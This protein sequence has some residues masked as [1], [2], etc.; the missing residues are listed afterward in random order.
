[1]SRKDRE[2]LRGLGREV[3]EIAALPAQ[4]ETISLWKALNGLKPVRPMVSIDQVCWHEMNVDGELAPATEDEFCRTLET[5]LRRILYGWKHMRV[6]MVVEPV[7]SVSKVIRN[8]GFGIQVQERRAVS[9]PRNGVVGHFY[10]DQFAEDGDLEKLK[11][12]QVSL[13]RL[14]TAEAEEKANGIFDGILP[15]RLQ[16]ATPNFAVWDLITQ[17]RGGQNVLMDL[18]VRPEFTHRLM[19]RLTDAYLAFLDQMETQG[20]LA[21]AQPTIHC[22]GAWTDEL[23]APG[24]D[25]KKPRA[26][27]L[28]TCGMAQIFSSVS[29]S[30]H[31]EFELDY[32]VRWYDRFGLNYYGCCE[33]LHDKIDIIRAIPRLR[34]ISMSPWVDVEKGAERI[35]R[36]FVFSRK[37][38]PAFLAMDWSPADVEKDLRDTRDRCARHGTPLELVLKDISTVGYKPRKLWEWADIAMRVVRG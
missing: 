8:T 31:K 21:S 25:A 16:G 12:P 20:L 17:W 33:P 7:V 29:P 10:L 15:V 37:P 36:D 13:D 35:G 1:V 26:R 18:A 19:A 38:S 24:Y 5:N 6:D 3:A 27:D 34:K 9:D 30:M 28:W 23:P 2:V 32:A 14:A 4:K 11:V 22:A